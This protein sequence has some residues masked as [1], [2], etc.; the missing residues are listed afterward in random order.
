MML[1]SIFTVYNIQIPLLGVY[2]VVSPMFMAIVYNIRIP[3]LGVYYVV[4]P[5]FMASL[6]L[7]SS[8]KW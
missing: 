7:K 6:V 8:S 4:S 3:P 5:I 2:H 1:N